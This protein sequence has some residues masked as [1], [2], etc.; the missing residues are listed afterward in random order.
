MSRPLRIEY[1][2]AY[3]HVM[4]RGRAR[5][6]I[7]PDE[8]YYQ[9][10]LATIEEAYQRFSLLVHAY[11]LM[12]NHYHL[13][14]S[15]PEA[16]L[17]R[18]MRHVNG[19]YTQRYNRLKRID[20]PLFRGRYKAILV[21]KDNYL[22]QVSRYIHRNPCEAGIVADISDYVW[23]SYP[24][25]ERRRRCPSWL[26]VTQVL[27][28]LNSNKP[29]HRY[30]LYVAG[31]N[32]EELVRFYGSKR[33]SSLLG[34]KDFYNEMRGRYDES[35]SEITT[36][37]RRIFRPGLEEVVA[38]VMEVFR[39]EEQSIVRSHKGKK[40]VNVARLAA[41]KLCKEITGAKLTEIAMY[42]NVSHYGTV[43]NAINRVEQ[44][45]EVDNKLNRKYKNVIKR[46]DP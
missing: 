28:G 42:F 9:T 23:S 17:G 46:F 19:V 31:G 10:F 14:V 20:G 15:T 11:C 12:P 1:P 3:Y 39:T 18:A 26:S 40:Q 2:N 25:Y 6:R 21:D 45:L 27:G 32:D 41:M 30:K 13:L 5:Q 16:N 43:A 38:A 34:Q 44:I 7:F 24:V 35:K 4:N 37:E 29:Y 8:E 36:E 22:L 33:V